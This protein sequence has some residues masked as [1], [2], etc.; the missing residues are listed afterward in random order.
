[1]R[2]VTITNLRHEQERVRV[3]EPPCWEGRFNIGLGHTLLCMVE[4]V[5]RGRR[6]FVQW[7]RTA[8]DQEW[9]ELDRVNYEEYVDW[10][11][12]D[13]DAGLTLIP[14]RR[15]KPPGWFTKRNKQAGFLGVVCLVFLS[16]CTPY[17]HPKPGPWP[18][19]WGMSEEGMESMRGEQARQRARMMSGPSTLGAG[20]SY[21][22]APPTSTRP[23]EFWIY[24]Q[25]VLTAV[26][27][28]EQLWDACSIYGVDQS[29]WDHVTNL[30]REATP[31]RNY[32]RGY[33]D[34]N[35]RLNTGPKTFTGTSVLP[36]IEELPRTSPTWE[37][38][39]QYEVES[40]LGIGGFFNGR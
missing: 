12:R 11:T 1:M 8:K 40:G 10:I 7:E 33:N 5:T 31:F 16:S 39:Y 4:Q 27:P 37:D 23:S 15:P 3:P 2:Q 17:T 19:Y 38:G 21:L 30:A 14:Y 13:Y 32:Y 6:C 28:K 25:S 20:L 24:T 9:K 22:Y 35:Q 34:R 18:S 29:E 26:P 36:H